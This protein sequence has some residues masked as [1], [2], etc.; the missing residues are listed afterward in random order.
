MAEIY[1]GIDTIGAKKSQAFNVLAKLIEGTKGKFGKQM[2]KRKI[3]DKVGDIAQFIGNKFIPGAGNIADLLIDQISARNIDIPG[4]E[5]IAGQKGWA[6][7]AA[8]DASEE[9]RR[10]AESV[11][12]DK[13]LLSDIL[14]EGVE[15]AGSE[16]GGKALEKGGDWF[17]EKG[18]DWLART[19]GIGGKEFGAKVTAQ[20]LKDNPWLSSDT[21]TDW[22]EGGQ[23]PK[24]YYGGGNVQG[25]DTAPSIVDYFASQNK[26]L[27]GSDT[28][29]LAEKLRGR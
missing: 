17:K 20:G 12:P 23:V 27:G 7:S 5:E 18:G 14:Q 2:G 3:W 22:R 19:F 11:D 9:F 21:I 4:G 26:T 13:T 10:M 1:E 28:M 6:A 8:K 25:G 29:S 16:V 15:F 24:K